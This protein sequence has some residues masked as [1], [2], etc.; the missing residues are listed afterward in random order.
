MTKK[1][2]LGF[3]LLF[4]GVLSAGCEDTIIVDAIKPPAIQVHTNRLDFG[5]QNVGQRTTLGL[6]ISNTGDSS[7]QISDLTIHPGDFIFGIDGPTSMAIHPGATEVVNVYFW[8]TAI[9]QYTAS[10][11]IYSDAMN[12]DNTAGTNENVPQDSVIL[13]QLAGEGVTFCQECSSP[14]SSVCLPSGDLLRFLEEGECQEDGECEYTAVVEEC[15]GFCDEETLLCVDGDVDAGVYTPAPVTQPDAGSSPTVEV[16]DAGTPA[17]PVGE[18]DAGPVIAPCADQDEDGICNDDDNCPGSANTDQADADNDG[19][20]DVCDLCPGHDDDADADGDVV[21]DGCDNCP[22]DSNLDQVNSDD[23]SFGDA[24]DNCPYAD[25]Q[26]QANSDSD[27]LGDVCDNCPNETNEN[28]ENDDNDGHGNTCDNCPNDDNEDQANNDDDS[29]GDVCDN[30]PSVD[31]EAQTNSDNDTHG[32][33]CDNCP[34][35]DNEAQTNS[36]NDTHGDACD[37]CL[38]GNNEDQV[39]SDSDDFGDACD[40]CPNDGTKTEPGYCG[41]GVE[42]DYIDTDSDGTH[43]C[44]DG[45]PNDPDKTEPGLCGCGE[46]EEQ[47]CGGL[48]F[49]GMSNWPPPNS[50]QPMDPWRFTRQDGMSQNGSPDPDEPIVIDSATQLQ[51]RGCLRGLRGPNCETSEGASSG[52]AAEAYTTHSTACDLSNWGGYGDWRLPTIQEL[53]SLT[54][55]NYTNSPLPPDTVFPVLAGA[56][57]SSSRMDSNNPTFFYMNFDSSAGY[58]GTI[59]MGYSNTELAA[60]CVRA[61]PENNRCFVEESD[62]GDNVI[63]DPTANLMWQKG[64]WGNNGTWTY[65]PSESFSS[66]NYPVTDIC[67]ESPFGG[68]NDWRMPTIEELT[69]LMH[70]SGDPSEGFPAEVFD[71]PSNYGD[72]FWSTSLLDDSFSKRWIYYHYNGLIDDAEANS[73]YCYV[74]CV[75]DVD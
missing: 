68:W 52:Y 3:I 30:C 73:D 33:A 62:S 55:Y 24:C 65:N 66:N 6:K 23:D 1:T 71:F 47:D 9:D 42:D 2:I 29:F 70:F 69:S 31:N 13:V 49:E 39:N 74:R 63:T 21:P 40:D 72:C 43:D 25:N 19:V 28:Q 34:S 14:P 64:Y 67:G 35:D 18:I 75:R 61:G 20:G 12:A 10:L 4:T 36:D 56:A 11:K 22:N 46:A 15:D 41:C 38:I 26:D 60:L 27:T 44:M 51:W 54:D 48:C 57:W 50:A 53:A 5:S 16:P 45:C 8:P 7:L 17:P 32:D 59:S 37:N 58:G